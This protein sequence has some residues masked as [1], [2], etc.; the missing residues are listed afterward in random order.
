MT[1]PNGDPAQMA[2]L[3]RAVGERVRAARVTAGLSQSGLERAADLLPTTVTKLERGE[4]W[5]VTIGDLIRMAYA[6]GVHART[7]LPDDEVTTKI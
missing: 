5:N 7:L 6:L 1:E 2:E 3:A 4:V